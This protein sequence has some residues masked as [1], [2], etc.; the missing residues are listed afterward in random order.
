MITSSFVTLKRLHLTL[1][2]ENSFYKM[3]PPII[4][5]YYDILLGLP[6]PFKRYW[7]VLI[8][9]PDMEE[10]LIQKFRYSRL[11]SLYPLCPRGVPFEKISFNERAPY[12]LLS[13]SPI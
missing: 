4:G 6:K 13:K 11:R 10:I 12:F 7:R 5:W 8:R 1:S 3:L 2:L 9:L